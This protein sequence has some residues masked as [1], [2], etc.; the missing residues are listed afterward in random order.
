MEHIQLNDG[1]SIQIIEKLQ[2]YNSDHIYYEIQL[3]NKNLI[4]TSKVEFN[5]LV[6][7]DRESNSEEGKLSLFHSYFWTFDLSRLR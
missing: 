4:I 3:E 6:K 2:S 1:N 5:A 7:T